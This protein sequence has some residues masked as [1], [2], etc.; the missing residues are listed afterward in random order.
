MT[1]K[2]QLLQ[3]VFKTID[4]TMQTA[5]SDYNELILG[6]SASGDLTKEMAQRTKEAMDTI[7]SISSGFQQSKAL[8]LVAELDEL[9]VAV[10]EVS[11]ECQGLLAERIMRKAAG[12]ELI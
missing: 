7:K 6:Y 11:N 1:E 2:Q 8:L 10:N 9:R 4:T 5:I 12:E 3:D